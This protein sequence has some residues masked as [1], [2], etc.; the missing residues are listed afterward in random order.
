M[1]PGRNPS[2]T[3]AR[4]RPSPGRIRAP[5]R[6]EAPN[7]HRRAEAAAKRPPDARGRRA[8]RTHRDRPLQEMR[9]PALERT[10]AH[11]LLMNGNPHRIRPHRGR[12]PGSRPPRASPPPGAPRPAK[13]RRRILRSGAP[14][15]ASPPAGKALGS[16]RRRSS[17]D[18]PPSSTPAKDGPSAPNIL[19]NRTAGMPPRNSEA[20]NKADSTSRPR[21]PHVSRTVCA[22]TPVP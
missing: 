13:L 14:R 15:R 22:P 7:G 11:H 2:P 21:P 9:K 8:H 16:K 1:R 4:R 3:T 17:E 20:D 6:V 10:G 12:V 18:G 5:E 19:S